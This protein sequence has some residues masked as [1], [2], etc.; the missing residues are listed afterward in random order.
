MRLRV[1]TRPSR[2]AIAQVEEVR[3]FF[4]GLIFNVMQIATKGDKDKVSSLTVRENTD[5]FTY[6]LEQALL[7]DQIDIAIHSAKDLDENMPNSLSIALMTPSISCFDCLV[8]RGGYTLDTLPSG[9]VLG[10]SSVNRNESIKRYRN[11]LDVKDIRGNIDQRVEKLDRGEYDAVIVAHAALLRLGLEK[12]I[13]QIIP[14]NVITPHPLQ[15]AL[16]VQIKED[17]V[18]LKN[19]LNNSMYMQKVV[20]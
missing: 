4:P 20:S 13:S 12:R 19:I 16:A 1:G 9:A 14:L 11:D 17:N 10:T 5:F 15:G 18:R 2:L 3:S 8:A 7:H 6:E